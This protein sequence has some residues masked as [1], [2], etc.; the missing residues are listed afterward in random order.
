MTPP[1]E[2]HPS[3]NHSPRN[4]TPISILVLHATA[5]SYAS[6][7]AWLCNPAS[8]VS[9]HYLIR[10]DGHI[11]Q[12]VPDART[13]WHAGR[14]V[15]HGVMNINARSIGVE[16]EN[17]ND[18]HDPYP[19]A[20]L[21]SAHALCQSLVA[22][23]NI[24][25]GDVVRHLDI[26]PGRKSDP[27]GLPWPAFADS[28]YLDSAPPLAERRYRVKARVTAGA[29]IRS[30]PRTNAAVMGRL[31]AGDAWAGLP[32]TG[33]RVTIAGFGSSDEW[34]CSAR[35]HCVWSGLLEEAR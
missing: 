22:R 6:A 29:T 1:I 13:A 2:Q 14:S 19:P 21:A 5:G 25:R 4:G 35:M 8:R 16:L 31:H 20:Q 27:A 23:Y 34:I 3:P 30:A 11:V 9:S 10:R 12:L 24:E 15:W 17:A 26:A 7:L 32:E 18:G 33:Q 28:L